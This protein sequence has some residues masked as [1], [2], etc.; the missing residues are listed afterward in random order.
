M[1]IKEALTMTI[2]E[3][4]ELMENMKQDNQKR[5]EEWKKANQKE[6]E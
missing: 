3:K 1:N 2:K 5:V 4:L 6:V